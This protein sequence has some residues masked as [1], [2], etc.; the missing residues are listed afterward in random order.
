MLVYELV[1]T[2]VASAHTNLNLAAGHF[3]LDPFRAELV[4]TGALAEEHH[5]QLAA[6]WVVV[7]ELSHLEINLV[8]FDRH[9]DSYLPLELHNVQLQSVALLFRTPD[10][11]QQIQALLIGSQDFLLQLDDIVRGIG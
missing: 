11:L 2:E 3:H 1:N 8:S 10:N 9:I 6:L 4:H 5:L 7:D